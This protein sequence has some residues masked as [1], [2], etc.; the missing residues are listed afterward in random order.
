[1]DSALLNRADELYPVL[2][3]AFA[4][5]GIQWPVM[6]RSTHPPTAFLLALPFALIN[7]RLSQ[8]LWMTAMFACIV[9]AAHVLGLTW[10]KS[11]IAGVLSI[12]WPPAIWSLFNFTPI[13]L[14]GLV[15]AYRFR[16]RSLASGVWIAI[17]S[18]PKY[19][20]AS[21]LLYHLKYRKWKALLSFGAVWLGALTMLLLLRPDAISAY[22]TSNINNSFDQIYRPDNGA[23]L[24]VAWR[25]GKGIGLAAAIALILWV[26]WSGLQRNNRAGWACLVWVGIALLPIAWVYSLLPLLPWLLL[27]LRD[28]RISS[29][30]LAR[31]ALLVPYM[32]SVPTQNPWSVALC[33][34]LAGVAF[35][36]TSMGD[37]QETNTN[38]ESKLQV[39]DIQSHGQ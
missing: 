3:P 31:A 22:F 39:T 28:S 21:A 25:L 34:A 24:V 5:M 14:L 32:G 16:G 19:L 29:R 30:F 4:Q 8:F 9:L 13:W 1:M 26:L 27:V 36:I 33:I 12:A 35:A 2:G 23:L 17:A 38:F 11:L 10:Q 20:A 6:H 7:Y 18:L 37:K 15:L